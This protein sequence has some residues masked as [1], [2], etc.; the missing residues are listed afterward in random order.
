MTEFLLALEHYESACNTYGDESPEAI[1]CFRQSI[2][3]MP[4]AMQAELTASAHSLGLIPKPSAYTDTNLPLYK[5]EDI[6]KHLNLPTDLIEDTLNEIEQDVG[7]SL[8]FSGPVHRL[9]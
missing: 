6:A 8:K 4:E 3:L 2:K 9:Q 7:T 1:K 5:V